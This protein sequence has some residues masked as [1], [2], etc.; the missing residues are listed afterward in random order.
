M[1]YGCAC[2]AAPGGRDRYAGYH[3]RPPRPAM[4]LPACL[5]QNLRGGR[6]KLQSIMMPEMEFSHPEKGGWMVGW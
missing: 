5:L 2:A 3:P 6:V 4:L 1:R